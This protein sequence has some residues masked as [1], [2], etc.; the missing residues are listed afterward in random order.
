MAQ[1]KNS[2]HDLKEHSL[3]KHCLLSDPIEVLLGNKLY[4]NL[5]DDDKDKR[6]P[7]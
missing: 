4:M 3:S 7:D 2:P 6:R 1:L 5:R